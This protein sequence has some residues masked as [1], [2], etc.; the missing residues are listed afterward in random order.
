MDNL[1]VSSPGELSTDLIQGG[2]RYERISLVSPGT[3]TLSSI[4]IRF[5]AVR[6]TAKDY[7]GWFDSS[8]SQLNRIWYDGAYTLQLDE[9]PA[10]AVPGPWNVINGVL[11]GNGGGSGLLRIGSSWSNY[12]MSFDS[13]PTG[14]EVGWLVRAQSARMGYLFLLDGSADRTGLRA[15]C[16]RLR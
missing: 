9:L 5:T 12:T 14:E 2:E 7:K 1:I 10:D 13:Q 6:A 16:A 3:V 4:G 11:N 15:R 8:S